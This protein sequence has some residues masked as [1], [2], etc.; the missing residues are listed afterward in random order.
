MNKE[1]ERYNLNGMFAAYVTLMEEIDNNKIQSI[2]EL[3]AKILSK[4]EVV[5]ELM[6]INENQ[7]I[8]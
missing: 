1:Q 3:R 6:T 4:M 5:H 7:T 2:S 8:N